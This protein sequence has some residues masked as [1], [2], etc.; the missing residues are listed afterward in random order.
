MKNNILLSVLLAMVLASCA[1]G[2][3]VV[4]TTQEFV[5]VDPDATPV[6]NLKTVEWDVWNRQEMAEEAAKDSNKDKVYYVITPEQATNLFDNLI[7]ISDLVSKSVESNKF[8]KKSIDEYRK[9]KAK[10]E[11]DAVKSKE[12][13][14]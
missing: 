9:A 14:K 2:Q 6:L 13:K 10:A 5:I 1:T 4:P 12:I 11:K 7:A 3:K 8:Y